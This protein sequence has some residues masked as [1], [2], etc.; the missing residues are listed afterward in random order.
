MKKN[1]STPTLAGRRRLLGALAAAGSVPTAARAGLPVGAKP[2]PA[3]VTADEVVARERWLLRR[4][5]R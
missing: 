3:A 1:R 5:D 2:D 4:D